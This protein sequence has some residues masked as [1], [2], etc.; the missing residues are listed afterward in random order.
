MDAPQVASHFLEL[1]ESSELLSAQQLRT[2]VGK[3]D[4]VAAP[5]AEEA[6]LRLVSAGLLTRFQG[7][8]LL[9]G[10]ARGFYYDRYKLLD[11][12]GHGGMSCVYRAEDTQTGGQVALKVLAE[13]Y[14]HDAGMITR[15][16]LE[17]LVGRK[18]RHPHVLHT[19]GIG[20]AAGVL[21]IVMEHFEAIELQE[22]IDN[23]GPLPVA[24]ACDVILQAAIGLHAA[25]RT[26]IVHRDVKPANLMIDRAGDVKVL[27]FGLSLL[28]PDV[29]DEEF[30]L[31]MIFGH[32]CLGTAYYM[33]PE[34][35][36][37]SNS[38]DARAD[39]YGLGCTMYH[40]LA[41]RVPF[42]VVKGTDIASVPQV[43][44]AHRE[45]PLPPLKEF[46]P[47]LPREVARVVDRMT[48]KNPDDRFAT[49]A[50]VARALEPFAVRRPIDVDV[51]KILSR[52]IRKARQRLTASQT[53]SS[54]SA[55]TR[56]GSQSGSSVIGSG[57]Q[58]SAS[59][60]DTAVS[61][62]TRPEHKSAIR[63]GGPAAATAS[64]S[65]AAHDALQTEMAAAAGPVSRPGFLL[66]A[67]GAPP[68]CLDKGRIVIGRDADC[69]VVLA[70]GQVSGK[71]CELRHED[72][73]WHVVDLGSKNGVLV[74]GKFVKNAPLR[75]GDRLSIAHYVLFQF[76]GG[77]SAKS[78]RTWYW[79][80]GIALLLAAAAALAWLLDLL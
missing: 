17:A 80:A 47:E 41:G 11:V 70:A 50:D 46:V 37:D 23:S 56:L 57:L 13:R 62:D 58:R 10:R 35:S 77:E 65:S 64:P 69:D 44:A 27:D 61:H 30:S 6:A 72:G 43:I 21:Y 38:V 22:L 5:T 51:R 60:I 3:Y 75:T 28:G 12:L 53:G 2:A 39:I 31:A 34:Q 15:L 8:R 14:K 67:D 78:G 63:P 71:H 40:A 25:H 59:R 74:N 79:I 42:P 26:G 32:E 1:L 68:I 7:Q 45:R 55:V 20:E 48:A 52:R 54:Q 36:R 24:H 66:Q 18:L 49:A 73:R 19:L 29:A 33:P 4:L 76:Q 9:A 16:K